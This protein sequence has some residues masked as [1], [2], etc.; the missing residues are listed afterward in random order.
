MPRQGKASAGD[1]PL[2]AAEF[3]E[4]L[5]LRPE[6]AELRRVNAPLEIPVAE[7]GLP[8][9]GARPTPVEAEQDVTRDRS[10]GQIGDGS[11]DVVPSG[12]RRWEVRPVL[13]HHS[14]HLRYHQCSAQRRYSKAH[15]PPA[16]TL[17]LSPSRVGL[18][19]S[20]QLSSRSRW[21]T[22]RLESSSL[23]AL[24]CP[25]SLAALSRLLFHTLNPG[26]H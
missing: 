26:E 19:G 22:E 21:I 16:G 18:L 2:S 6:I 20:R 4:L 1:E 3:R 8:I 12:S 5:A 23:I 13:S 10:S 7:P 25:T 15:V 14:C 17:R 24:I 11:Y 9:K